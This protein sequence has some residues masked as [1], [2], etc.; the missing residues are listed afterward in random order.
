MLCKVRFYRHL[1]HSCDIF[2]GSIARSA[3]RP[4]FDIFRPAGATR[5]TDGGEIWHEGPLL[6]AKFYPH[7]YN[8]KGVGPQKLKFLLI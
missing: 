4:Y 3:S 8:D 6:H 7:R 1:L 2:S 5:C